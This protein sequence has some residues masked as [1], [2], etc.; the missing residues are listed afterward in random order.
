MKSARIVHSILGE[1][2]YEALEKAITKLGTKSV[3][4]IT[5]L[6]DALKIAPKSI[7]AFL[8]KELKSMDK[9]Q[10]KD[11]ELPWDK[12]AKILI[13]KKDEDVYAGHIAKAGKIVHEFSLCSIPQLAAHLLSFSEMYDEVPDQEQKEESSPKSEEKSPDQESSTKLS[14]ID[15]IRHQLK[16]LDDKIN[17]LMMLVASQNA[18]AEVKKSEEEPDLKKKFI[19]SVK[20]YKL[21]KGGL[22]PG[23]PKPPKPGSNVGGSNG[24]TQAGVHS[25]KT[26]HSDIGKAPKTHE[27]NNPFLKAPKTTTA[28]PKQP[29]QPSLASSEKVP[30]KILTFQKSELSNKCTD[31]GQ[32]ASDCACFRALSKPEIKKSDAKSITFKFNGDWDSESISALYKSIRRLKD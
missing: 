13:N 9:D 31:C 4:D 27:N 1:H 3:V 12:E 24:L 16:Y 17:A 32:I 15:S 22:A 23:M 19:D 20:K 8:M 11:I 14:D 21:A 30:E 28:Q 10:A 29:K 6:H 25:D 2:A 7:I 26:P 18:P 5:E